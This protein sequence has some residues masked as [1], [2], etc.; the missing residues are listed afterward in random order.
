MKRCLLPQ[1]S[2]LQGLWGW[3]VGPGTKAC[4]AACCPRAPCPSRAVGWV[5][6]PG[7]KVGSATCHPRPPCPRPG[8]LPTRALLPP[9]LLLP[10]AGEASV[11]EYHHYG[12]AAPLYT[13]FTSP[14]RR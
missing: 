14:I 1:R 6:G 13:H 11:P 12:L 10:P 4:S 2:L 3:V 8:A 5:V 7:T 9:A